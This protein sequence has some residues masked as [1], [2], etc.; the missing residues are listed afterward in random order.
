[1]ID[2]AT[3]TPAQ[4]RKFLARRDDLLHHIEVVQGVRTLEPF[5]KR[6]VRAVQSHSRVA[7]S[8]CHDVG[9]TF[10]SSKLVLALGSSYPGAKIITTAPTFT[11]VETLLWAEIR[12]GY[13]KSVTPLGGNM[14]TTRWNLG[15]DWFALGMSPKEDAAQGEGQG[16]ASSFQGFHGSLTV[17]VFDEATGVPAGRWKQAEGMMTSHHVKFIAIGNPT[18]RSSPFFKCFSNPAWHKVRLSCF[19]SPNLRVN[20]ITNLAELTREIDRVREMPEAKAAER[21]AGYKVVQPRLLTLQWV[22]AYIIPLGFDHPLV[23]SKVLGEFPEEDERSLFPLGQIEEAQRREYTPSKAHDIYSIGCDVA[24]YGTDKTKITSQHGRK[25]FSPK[26]LVKKSNMEVAGE[27]VLEIK[28]ALDLVARP[29]QIR[30]V[31]DGTGL[32]SGVVDALKEARQNGVFPHTVEI[33]DVNFGERFVNVVDPVQREEWE[34]LYF[35]RKALMFWRLRDALRKN[36]VLPQ[37]EAYQDELPTLIYQVDSVGKIRIESKDEY[38]KR[39]GRSSPD[40][41]DSLALANE[42][43]HESPDGGKFEQI[44][45][46]GENIAPGMDQGDQW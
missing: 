34:R 9:K 21:I 10:T 35:N 16:T 12:A 29:D 14:L 7:I 39:T 44:D 23:V 22:V 2:L 6:V 36:L 24:R 11:Q 37:D 38:K 25:V 42:G 27:L 43:Q 5:Q 28:K 17:V 46:G 33:R 18:S 32:G 19:D 26:T 20:G 41:A 40:T 4:A 31:I 1:V 3:I 30:V 13:A 8:A 45:L 15:P